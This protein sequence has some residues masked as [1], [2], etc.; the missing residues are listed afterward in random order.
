MA[1]NIII[2]VSMMRQKTMADIGE[3]EKKSSL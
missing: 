2:I 3:N 1:D